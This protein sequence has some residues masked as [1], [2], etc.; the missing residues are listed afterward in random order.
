MKRAALYIRVSTEEQ[1]R[2]G[3]SIAEQKHDLTEYA[4]ANGYAVV[5]VYADEGVS[6]RKAMSRRHALQRLLADV[7]AGKIDVIII[8][9]LDRFFRN[10]KDFYK[11][12]EHLD[13]HGVEWTCTQEDFNTTT[14]NGRLMLNLKLSLAQ[15]ESD[16]TSERLKYVFEGMKRKKIPLSGALPYGYKVERFDGRRRIVLEP[17]EAENVKKIFEFFLRERSIRKARDFANKLC[18]RKLVIC[19]IRK[20]LT[21]PSYKGERH[22][23][24]DY[25]PAII[26]PE[27][28]GRVQ[29]IIKQRATIFDRSKSTGNIYLFSRLIHCPFCG[30]RLHG[31][32]SGLKTSDNTINYTCRMYYRERKC[33]YSKTIMQTTLEKWLL[34]NIQRLVCEYIT[35]ARAAAAKKRNK[36]PADTVKET[37]GKLA[38]LSRVFV[39]GLIS[40]EEY[41][42]EKAALEGVL[43]AA[44]ASTHHEGTIEPPSM[45]K[46]Q[47]IIDG[48]FRAIYDSLTPEGKRTFWHSIIERI[49]PQKDAAKGK[50]GI[51]YY[52]VRFQ[53]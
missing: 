50:G 20:I 52:T 18:G 46:Y 7:T 36:S 17:K 43:S 16:Q 21:N 37:R 34:A 25:C 44:L 6:A 23:I 47:A 42:R 41:E 29:D 53:P 14:A 13:A 31:G 32:R 19:S 30:G 35:D 10:V 51:K 4:R 24:A 48:G 2:H 22:G 49:E 40:S 45:E 27:V 9:C 3:Y 26:A 5:D 12:Q 33:T 28:F 39:D 1:A 11:V 15:H 38:R 8:K